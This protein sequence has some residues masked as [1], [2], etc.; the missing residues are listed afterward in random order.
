MKLKTDDL[1][2]AVVKT[3][4]YADIFNYPLTIKELHKFLIYKKKTSLKALLYAIKTLE[5]NSVINQRQSYLFLKGRNQILEKR[6]QRKKYSHQKL[7]IAQK[8]GDWLKLIPA[9]QAIAVTGTLAMENTKKEDDIDLMIITSKNRLWLTRIFVIALVSLIAKRR[10]PGILKTED[11][12]WNNAICLNLFLDTSTISI[13]KTRQNLYT[14][15]EVVQTKFLWSRNKTKEKF[16]MKNYWILNYL[17]NSNIPKQPKK[18][19]PARRSLEFWKQLNNGAI[20]KFL[21]HL[22]FKLQ[23][24]Y[25][26]SKITEELVAKNYAYFHPRNTGKTILNKYQLSFQ[27][28][29][30]TINK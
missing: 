8:V 18:T 27:K 9:I 1:Q 2:V 28:K 7:K 15:H 4:C 19:M 25:M 23:F 14:A 30:N 13:P 24:L 5:N 22:A 20:S 3:L 21:E 17:P 12:R 16:L 11:G 29:I 6:L 10:T 26:K